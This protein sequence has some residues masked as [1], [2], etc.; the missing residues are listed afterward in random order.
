MNVK[1]TYSW[2]ANHNLFYRLEGSG[3]PAL[4]LRR[5]GCPWKNA[6]AAKKALDLIEAGW[7]IARS[8]VRFIHV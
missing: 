4:E 6:G 3:G 8:R 2:D 5:V 1:V 7:G